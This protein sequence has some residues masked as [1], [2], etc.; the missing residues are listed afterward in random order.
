MN[1]FQHVARTWAQYRTFRSTLAELQG[2]TDRQL[3]DMGFARGDVARIA[4]EAAE[5][6]QATHKAAR[7]AA[8]G[9][10]WPTRAV[11]AR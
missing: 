1:V 9:F 3:A 6:D 8:P 7:D 5:L 4:Y 11:A 10:A 2:C